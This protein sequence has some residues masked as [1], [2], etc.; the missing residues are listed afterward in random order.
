MG[1]LT[2]VVEIPA[3]AMF[4]APQ[5]LAFGGPIGPEFIRH[6]DSGNIAQTLQ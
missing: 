3:L 1:D 5:D 2:A 4:N 6:D